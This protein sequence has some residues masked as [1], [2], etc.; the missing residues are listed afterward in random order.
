MARAVP[1]LVDARE[2]TGDGGGNH[3]WALRPV[4][5][6]EQTLA[7]SLRLDPQTSSR[8]NSSDRPASRRVFAW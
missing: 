1:R 7:L 5:Q 6:S 8:K 3:A 2:P 4:L